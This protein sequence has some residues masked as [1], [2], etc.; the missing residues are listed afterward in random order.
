MASKKNKGKQ[1]ILVGVK[2]F[3]LTLILFI[4]SLGVLLSLPKGVGLVQSKVAANSSL[5]A[6]QVAGVE[7]VP[8]ISLQSKGLTPPLLTAAAALALDFD[9]GQI[10]YQKDIHKRLLPASTT[11]L[12]TALVAIDYY[13]LSDPLT[14]FSDDLVGGSIMGLHEGEK[15]SFR[16]LLYGMLLN[17]GNDA[18]FTIAS[19]YPGG[20]NNFI[21]AMNQKAQSLGLLD[22]RFANPAGFDD[23]LQY[24]SAYDLSQIGL[25]ASLNTELAKVT[26]TKD[27]IVYSSDSTQGHSLRNVNQLLGQNGVIGIKTGYTDQAGENLV[28]LVEREGHKV[29]TVVLA[30]KDR[31]GETKTLM[32]WVYNDYVW[33]IIQ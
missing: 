3:S 31:F 24:S 20:L 27:T 14:V 9:S 8:T 4:I 18:A 21:S 12:M 23:P 25:A 33:K 13:K 15:V 16:S 29:L 17:S 1:G 28:G 22:T 19:N 26:S 10:I 30:S 11:K 32:D 6:S 7:K 5:Q 2:F